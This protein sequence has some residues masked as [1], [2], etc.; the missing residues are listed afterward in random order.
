MIPPP[1][2]VTLQRETVPVGHL[3]CLCGHRRRFFQSGRVR[4]RLGPAAGAVMPVLVHHSGVAELDAK[5]TRARE[6]GLWRDGDGVAS[7]G[8]GDSEADVAGGG[9][10][11]GGGGGGAPVWVRYRALHARTL[12][13]SC[14]P[15]VCR[16]DGGGS[17]GNGGNG[18]RGAVLT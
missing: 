7:G 18:T 16:D 8:G 3:R 6:A 12:L 14:E 15:R 9:G 13:H 17:G 10:G 11:K 1:V 5:V 2:R 4:D